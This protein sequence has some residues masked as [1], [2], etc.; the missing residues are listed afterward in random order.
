MIHVGK[1]GIPG[2]Q[3]A[4]LPFAAFSLSSI[5]ARKIQ[6]PAKHKGELEWKQ[7]SHVGTYTLFVIILFGWL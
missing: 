5:T 4:A 7:R 2:K 3:E 6:H 1:V